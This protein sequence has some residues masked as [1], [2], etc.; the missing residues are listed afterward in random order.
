MLNSGSVQS[1]FG[2]VTLASTFILLTFFVMMMILTSQT[3]VIEK[4]QNSIQHV[5][6]VGAYVLISVG[7]WS[8]L[9]SVFASAFT[10]ILSV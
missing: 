9:L 10:T 5:K 1:F 7:C 4:A 3:W 2:V 8:I 6:Q